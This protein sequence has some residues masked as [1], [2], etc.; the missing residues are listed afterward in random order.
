MAHS[1]LGD[2]LKDQGKLD[3][4]IACYRQAIELDPKFAVAHSNLGNALKTQ[5]KLDE[6]IACYRQAIELDPKLATAHNKPRRRPVVTRASWTRPSPSYRQAIELDPKYAHGSQQPRRRPEGS[7]QAGRGHRLLSHRP[8]NSTR[9]T[10]TAHAS[11]GNALHHQGQLDEAIACY[12]Q[13]IELDPK[14]AVAHNNLGVALKQQGRLDEAIA[15]GRQA[16]ELDPNYA[17]AYSNLGLALSSKGDVSDAIATLQKAIDRWPHDVDLRLNMSHVL[18]NADPSFRDF[19]RA[20]EHAQ[21]GTELAPENSG[22]WEN[23]GEA[24]YGCGQFAEAVASLEKAQQLGREL[25]TGTRLVLAMAYWHTGNRDKACEHYVGAAARFD[26][27]NPSDHFRLRDELETLIGAEALIRY[28]TDRLATDPDSPNLLL[29]GPPRGPGRVNSTRPP[30]TTPRRC[31]CSLSPRIRGGVRSSIPPIARVGATQ[32]PWLFIAGT[33]MPIAGS[34]ASS[35]LVLPTRRIQ[36]LPNGLPRRAYCLPTP[37]I[38]STCATA[39]RAGRDHRS[40]R[41]GQSTGFTWPK[42][43]ADY[44]GGDFET[45]VASAKTSREHA[46]QQLYVDAT[47]LLVQAMAEHQLGRLAEARQSLSDALELMQQ[48]IPTPDGGALGRD[49]SSWL[50][51]QILRR[52]AEA[53]IDPQEDGEARPQRK[54]GRRI[55]ESRRQVRICQ[56]LNDKSRPV[57]Q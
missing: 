11:L 7:G 26:E 21:R 57:S 50:R 44:R 30:R 52:E 29:R 15:E 32:R 5:G 27:R 46:G 19:P 54:P 55:I 42:S 1:N 24:Q 40:R 8:S 31:G 48:R 35:W 34:A 28:C 41:R 14:L 49:W 38:S 36:R 37:P 9:N 23:L 51:F 45:A 43:L 53:L 2:A 20:R 3:E 16:I 22:I 33:P 6:A 12:R 56:E 10:L 13:A 4:A 17:G 25:P 39:C 18:V 47:A